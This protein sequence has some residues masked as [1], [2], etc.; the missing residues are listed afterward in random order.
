M[1]RVSA[2]NQSFRRGQALGFTVAELFT[3]LLFLVLLILAAVE[4]NEKRATRVVQEKWNQVQKELEDAKK[5]AAALAEEDRGLREYFGV[6]NNFGDDFKDLVPGTNRVSDRQ[7]QQALR[8][9]AAASDE[10]NKLLNGGASSNQK[11]AEAGSK[12]DPQSLPAEVK[13][14]I[15]EKQRLQ[16][17]V[18]NVEERYGGTG[19]VFPSCWVTPT[20]G[21]EFV[22]DVA[23][24][25][26]PDGGR[27]V[28]H[29]GQVPGHDDEKTRLFSSVQFNQPLTDSDFLDETRQFYDFGTKQKPECRFFVRVNDRTAPQDK[30][31]FKEL[32]LTVEKNFYKAWGEGD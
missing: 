31:T 28:I 14:F 30:S 6:A 9:K 5:K 13:S 19:T 10:I 20:G 17:Q 21:T 18:A 24:T 1:D 3:L 8:E 29:D 2:D 25:S 7:T 4:Q 23:L 16:G 27:L 26:S 22:L 15:D 11:N 12:Y 32:L